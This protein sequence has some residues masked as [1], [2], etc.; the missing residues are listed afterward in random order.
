M[1]DFITNTIK[2]L[3]D[4]KGWVIAIS[5]VLAAVALMI[6][7]MKYL[8]ASEN[9]RPALWKKIKGTGIAAIG[10]VCAEGIVAVIL[11]YYM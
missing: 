1:P 2:L 6:Q 3:N 10:I 9:D 7:G 11:G 4:A 5:V 8:N